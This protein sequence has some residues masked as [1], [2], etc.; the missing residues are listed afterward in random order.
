[1][2]SYPKAGKYPDLDTV[3]AQCSGLDVDGGRWISYGYVIARKPR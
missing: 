3:C 2:N 1:M